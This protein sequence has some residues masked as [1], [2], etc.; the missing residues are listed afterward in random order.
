MTD[1]KPDQP[2]DSLK[3]KWSAYS[4]A[5][6]GCIAQIAQIPFEVVE[7]FLKSIP[8]LG[9]S[10]GDLFKLA[11]SNLQILIFLIIIAI[12]WSII[13]ESS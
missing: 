3:E 6:T 4:I 10:V 13:I 9:H 7:F 8:R 1:R 2:K 12:L 11:S 5:E